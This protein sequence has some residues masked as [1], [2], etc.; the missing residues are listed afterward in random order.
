MS[1]FL[2]RCAQAQRLVLWV[3]GDNQRSIAIYRHYGFE[4][5][6]LLDRIMILRRERHQ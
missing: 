6:G 5:D 2:A 4:L 1:S 3:I